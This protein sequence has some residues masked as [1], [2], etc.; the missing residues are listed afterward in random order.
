[1]NVNGYTIS[2]NVG[3]GDERLYEIS[4][5]KGERIIRVAGSL[6]LAV[7]CGPSATA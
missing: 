7:V 3:T 5:P 1:M 4:N 2:G 6:R